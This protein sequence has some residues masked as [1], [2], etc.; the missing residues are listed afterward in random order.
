M[1]SENN[2][3]MKVTIKEIRETKF[4]RFRG[5]AYCDTYTSYVVYV[6]NELADTFYNEEDIDKY[7]HYLKERKN[8]FEKVIKEIEI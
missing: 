6:D 8:D 4:S 7:I 1:Q 3:T 2:K 5:T